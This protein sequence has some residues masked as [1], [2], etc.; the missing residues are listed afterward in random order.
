MQTRNQGRVALMKTTCELD[1]TFDEYTSTYDEDKENEVN[2][3]KTR[4]NARMVLEHLNEKN[5][6][7]QEETMKLE[8]RVEEEEKSKKR[9]EDLV[10][11]FKNLDAQKL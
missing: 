1:D 4:K 11:Y 9:I 2:A 6:F 5:V 8:R 3:L 10:V 7:L